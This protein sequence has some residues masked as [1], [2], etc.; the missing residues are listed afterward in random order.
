MLK[1]LKKK[2]VSWLSNEDAVDAA[3][4]SAL[5]LIVAELRKD[6]TYSKKLR[7]FLNTRRE[8]SAIVEQLRFVKHGRGIA[9]FEDGNYVIVMKLVGERIDYDLFRVKNDAPRLIM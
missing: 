2:V 7:Q 5:R 6:L 8:G 1:R 9:A 4:E 3:Q